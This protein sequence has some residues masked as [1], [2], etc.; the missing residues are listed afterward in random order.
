MVCVFYFKKK[1]NWLLWIYDMVCVVSE[2]VSDE[3]G[4]SCV[5]DKLVKDKEVYK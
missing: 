2:V 4:S 1:I 3:A 5:K